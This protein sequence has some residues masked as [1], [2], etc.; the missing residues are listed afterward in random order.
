MEFSYHEHTLPRPRVRGAA[1]EDSALTAQNLVCLRACMHASALQKL[2]EYSSVRVCV[3]GMRVS[4]KHGYSPAIYNSCPPSEYLPFTHGTLEVGFISVG[5]FYF[6]LLLLVGGGPKPSE[7][8]YCISQP[9]RRRARA[10]VTL[11]QKR[12]RF[13]RPRFITKAVYKHTSTRIVPYL[14][15]DMIAPRQKQHV[16]SLGR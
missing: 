12:N 1:D 15:G 9:L 11:S 10:Q 14:A 2:Y 6:G 8:E 4:F 16:I 5:H 7:A 3:Q 13:F